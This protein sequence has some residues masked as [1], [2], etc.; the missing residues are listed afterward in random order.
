MKVERD[1]ALRPFN[2]LGLT[3]SAD[4]FVCVTSD[5]ELQSALQW[6]REHSLP[7]VPLGEG[8]N[9]VLAGNIRAL[10]L[11]QQTRGIEILAAGQD[12]VRLRVAAGENWHQLVAWSLQR[13]YFGLENLALIPGTAGAAPVQNI[14]AYGVE[15][16]TVL[17]EVRAT[18]ICD[19]EPLLFDRTAC[20]FGY[21][22][23]I[24]KRQLADQIVITAI[25]LQLSR[26]PVVNTSYPALSQYFDAKPISKL[27]PRDV[28]DAVVDI[29]RSRLP[30]PA[31]E[32]NAG[33]FFKNPVLDPGEAAR[34]MGRF[35]ALPS[36]P[37]S[38][39]SVKVPAAWMIEHCGWKGHRRGN[40]G[41][42]GQHALVLVNYGADS[43]EQLLQL[44]REIAES[45][46]QVF[47]IRLEM[48]PRA[49]GSGG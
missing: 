28:F 4:A 17:L 43:G 12:T 3:A 2:T 21:R 10:V 36:Y 26:I 44:A 1:R 49:Y 7:V 11:R 27:T 5:Q 39:G 45:V 20:D 42:H 35:P 18:R 8:S 22:D 37:Q 38:D 16:Q 34:V 40:L 23:S 15:L 31:V 33:S 41:V 30:D 9:V 48:E 13:G 29:R 47:G 14:G 24:F 25:D 19:G 6:A 32:P 46:Y